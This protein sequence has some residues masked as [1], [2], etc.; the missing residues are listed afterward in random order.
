VGGSAPVRRSPRGVR[1]PGGLSV[2]RG[3]AREASPERAGGGCPGRSVAP[4]V[5]GG[6]GSARAVVFFF[7]FFEERAFTYSVFRVNVAAGACLGQAQGEG[8]QLP[9]YNE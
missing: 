7:F 4:G 8:G 3:S 6:C 2:E 9:R 5:S 1:A